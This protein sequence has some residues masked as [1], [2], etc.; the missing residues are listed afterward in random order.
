MIET[1]FERYQFKGVHIAVQAVLTLYAQG[2][3]SWLCVFTKSILLLLS[4][5]AAF[6]FSFVFKLNYMN[7]IVNYS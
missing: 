6:Y 5:P 4:Y 1:M 7:H 3:D 2:T